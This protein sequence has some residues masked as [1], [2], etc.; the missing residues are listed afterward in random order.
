MNT[1]MNRHA[2]FVR[3]DGHCAQGACPVLDADDA[4][5]I[6]TTTDDDGGWA[7]PWADDEQEDTGA[8]A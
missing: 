7:G 2:P 1:N 4:A 5:P 8:E 6:V 3:C